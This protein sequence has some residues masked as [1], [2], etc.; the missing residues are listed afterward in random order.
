MLEVSDKMFCY[1]IPW[2]MQEHPKFKQIHFTST[3]KLSEV[4]VLEDKTNME[5]PIPAT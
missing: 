1:I 4:H 2:C 5:V 3:L